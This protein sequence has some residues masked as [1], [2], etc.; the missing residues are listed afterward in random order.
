MSLL[1][2][3]SIAAESMRA[4]QRALQTTGNN[5]ANVGTP[6]FS[7][8]RVELTTAFPSVE[9]RLVLGQGVEVEEIRSFVDR[10]LEAQLTSLSGGVGFN[11]SRGRALDSVVEAFPIEGSSGIGASLSAF[12]GAVSDLANNPSGRAERVSLVNRAQALGEN[13]RQSR[14]LLTSIQS[15]LDKDVNS[16]VTRLNVILPQIGDLNDQILQIEGTGQ[17][18]N[19][20]RDQR[21]LLIQEVTRLTGA[22]TL[23]NADGQVSMFVGSLLLVSGRRA[24]SF[25][26]SNLNPQGF[27]QVF[28]TSPDGLS[29]DASALLTEGELGGILQM[30]DVEIPATVGRVDQFAKTLVDEVNA[31]HAL[32]FDLNGTAGGD[33]FNPI[34]AVAGAAGSVRVNAAILADTHLIAAAQDAAGVPGDNRNALA[35]VNL[36]NTTFPALGNSTLQDFFLA[37]A[38]DVGADAKGSEDA[39]NFQNSLL[40]QARARREAV[41]GVNIE[42]ETI[43]LIQFQRAFE[44]SSLL[45]RT[46]DEMIQAVLEM[47][48]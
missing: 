9:G 6:G 24:A 4:Q 44:A 46:T 38:G 35:L 3:L 1:S 42:E 25:D 31:Q 26:D 41:S 39:L 8:Q 30:R 43:N 37:L 20:F 13:L 7:R 21:Q 22:T 34:A 47:V 11:E 32:G 19:D 2:T 18:A 12:F 27:R 45:V 48:R 23:E 16:V 28:F 36:Q 14:E 29:F 5:L 17:R 40:S 10:F 15:N 33:F